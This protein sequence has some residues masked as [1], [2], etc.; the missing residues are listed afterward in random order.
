MGPGVILARDLY[1]PD[2]LPAKFLS[3]IEDGF[4]VYGC[5][6]V[7]LMGKIVIRGVGE[8]DA[9][10][11]IGGN[12]ILMKGNVWVNG[13]IAVSSNDNL[14]TT[15][16]S[17][18]SGIVYS[19][20]KSPCPW[21]N[22]SEILSTIDSFDNSKIGWSEEMVILK[23]RRTIDL[24]DGI[25][26]VRNLKVLGNT[27][28]TGDKVVLFI[29][30][31]ISHGR[32][33]LSFKSGYIFTK[34]FISAGY[35]DLKGY[36]YGTDIRISGASNIVG[37]VA[38]NN[39]IVRGK[40]DIYLDE[41]VKCKEN[42]CEIPLKFSGQE[43]AQITLTPS[44]I[45]VGLP[46]LDPNRREEVINLL[47]SY[48]YDDCKEADVFLSISG[49]H[50]WVKS[51]CREPDIEGT[52][53]IFSVFNYLKSEGV[54][55]LGYG[56]F[57]NGERAKKAFVF[58]NY[59][60]LFF[61]LNHNL[62]ELK[63]EVS[64][65]VGKDNLKLEI[66]K[67]LREAFIYT[68]NVS[69]PEDLSSI[70]S[71][72]AVAQ[73]V[74]KIE[75]VEKVRFDIQIKKK[76]LEHWFSDPYEYAQWYLRGQYRVEDTYGS[77][78][79]AE[80]G[81]KYLYTG[82][83][84]EDYNTYH[85]LNDVI[86]AVLDSG[87]DYT[88]P[89]FVG[90][91]LKGCSVFGDDEDPVYPG[92]EEYTSNVPLP[93]GEHCG[94][95]MPFPAPDDED[96]W[97]DKKAYPDAAHGTAV[98]S[99][100]GALGGYY[101]LSL[102][103]IRGV[104]FGF[105]VKILPVQVL[106]YSGSGASDKQIR[107]G[108]EW[109]SEHGA[110]LFNNSWGNTRDIHHFPEAEDEVVNLIHTT[111]SLIVFASGNAG[112]S[113][114]A[115][116]SDST[117]NTVASPQRY[118]FSNKGVLVVG[119]LKPDGSPWYYSSSGT[120]VEISAPSNLATPFGILSIVCPT[121]TT[122]PPQWGNI[123]APGFIVDDTTG[124]GGMNPIWN[125]SDWEEVCPNLL[126]LSWDISP[127][128]GGTSAAAPLVTGVGASLYSLVTGMNGSLAE[129][130]LE[131]TTDKVPG[132]P[133]FCVGYGRVNAEK[134][135]RYVFS[136][137][138]GIYKGE[139]VTYETDIPATIH[140]GCSYF[141]WIWWAPREWK[142]YYSF[143]VTKPDAGDYPQIPGYL[144]ASV[145]QSPSDWS[146]LFQNE[147][148]NYLWN[149]IPWYGG[150]KGTFIVAAGKSRETTVRISHPYNKKSNTTIKLGIWTNNSGYFPDLTTSPEKVLKIHVISNAWHFHYF[151]IICGIP[152]WIG[153]P[154]VCP[155]CW[156]CQD[157][158]DQDV[159][160]CNTCEEDMNNGDLDSNACHE[161]VNYMINKPDSD[162]NE[163]SDECKSCVED[164][165]AGGWDYAMSTS[166]CTVCYQ[167]KEEAA[168]EDQDK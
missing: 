135:W 65:V 128:F 47:S 150:E 4:A 140:I 125:G 82:P 44:L 104:N 63:G 130:V 54:Y 13:D 165:L 103:G 90:K 118:L 19:Y 95:P 51:F 134:A 45:A 41:A 10:A 7:D 94:C 166:D 24:P 30:N 17:G 157:P 137:T 162:Y 143:G 79:H 114:L 64:A 100:I 15:G 115:G 25:Y 50:F 155:W 102:F 138:D 59:I 3:N 121:P 168:N 1:Y 38:G 48:G 43:A 84:G 62:D 123:D 110:M 158:V 156:K 75:G 139:D 37:K 21:W 33:N 122:S 167:Q 26:H 46:A 28:L 81:W 111:P 96:Y 18:N 29:D 31:F 76:L 97:F 58:T 163:E 5:S 93:S 85:S 113:N 101:I 69:S 70:S 61:D 107:E 126:N 11:N 83:S 105:N 73:R 151:P 87:V 109:A 160:V 39:V 117:Y 27:K 56:F 136:V 99:E 147:F 12:K 66:L 8:D 132:T 154:A 86:V 91:L 77:G 149:A 42:G 67:N 92:C 116:C 164:Y 78:I 34:N 112:N 129:E 127:V 60:D 148:A 57:D 144:V 9:T 159:Q 98:A 108:F 16:R 55:I 71:L 49:K 36:L 146:F 35:L 2:F 161:C 32:I 80:E 74:S 141:P 88:N 133:N 14:V 52:N 120:E 119:A 89:D 72:I 53:N 124:E 22:Y 153:G 106:W 142:G 145:L 131:K 6:N 40:S 152:C 23:G 68:N 20:L